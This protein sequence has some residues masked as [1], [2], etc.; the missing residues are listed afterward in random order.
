MKQ[1]RPADGGNQLVFDD[2][3]EA[4]VAQAKAAAGDSDVMMHGAYTAQQA[5]RAGVL[6][7]IDLQVR[8][9]LLGESRRLFDDL[10]TEHIELELV[11][12]LE[13]LGTVHLRYEVVHP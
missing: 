6:D 4:C 8:P 7:V 10:T 12:T 11:R 3:I 5:L 13:A 9:V 2:G 1:Y